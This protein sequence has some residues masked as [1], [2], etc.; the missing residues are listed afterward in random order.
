MG[1]K[2]VFFA[3][4]VQIED[5][6]GMKEV[7]KK[8]KISSQK[9][10]W[11]MHFVPSKNFHITVKYHGDVSDK[12]LIS[13]KKRHKELLKGVEPFH[14][15]VKNLGGFPSIEKTK[16]LWS[17]VQKSKHLVELVRRFEEDM[18]E[19]TPHITLAKL[20][21][22]KHTKEFISPFVRKDFGEI[23]VDRVSLFESIRQHRHPKYVLLQDVK[24]KER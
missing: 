9:K 1:V 23:Y 12:E 19:F 6:S 3:I 16:I 5:L 21:Y 4:P 14:L 8:L 11:D 15:K 7:L 2:K 17:G 22:R 18:Q 13:L 24:M 10:E 20:T